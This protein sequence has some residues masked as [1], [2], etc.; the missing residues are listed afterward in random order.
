MSEAAPQNPLFPVPAQPGER[1]PRMSTAGSMRV[2]LRMAE[3]AMVRSSDSVQVRGNTAH[4]LVD[5]SEAFPAWLDAIQS[6]RHYVH[7]ENYIIRDDRIGRRFREALCDRS[8]DGIRVRV[9]YDWIGCWATPRKFWRPFRDAGV[10]LRAFAPPSASDP[11]NFLRR[12]HRKVVAVDGV[13]ASTSGM[14]IGDEWA[15]DPEAGIPAW[16]DTGVE[17]RGPVAAA[18]DRAFARSWTAA[19]GRLPR[20]EIADPADVR[21]VGH[22]AVRVVEGEPGRSRIYRL[23]QFV[24][25]GVE[26]RLWITDPYFVLPPAMA[27]ALASAARDGVDVRVLVP[28]YNNWPIVGGMSRAGYRP[29]LDA[30]VR[31]FE[32]E[33]PMIHAKTAVADG[34][35]SRVGSTNL[36]LAS[37]L[38]NW[39]LDVAVTDLDFATE[40]EALFERDLAS[41]VEITM[42]RSSRVSGL[43]IRERRKVERAPLEDPEDLSTPTVAEAREARRRSFRGSQLGRFM[44]RL[45]RAA[46]VLMRALV[47]HRTIGREDTGWVT[48]WAAILVAVSL[49]GF[50]VPR[51]LAWPIAFLVFWLAVAALIRIGGSEDPPNPPLHR[52]DPVD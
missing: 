48:L 10:D 21:P 24:A 50:L 20:E 5:G 29:L 9:L 44:G 3:R 35:W 6:A 46:T 16:R 49:L 45:A 39:E 34:F 37:L 31:L 2:M 52:G 36:N 22:V 26:R 19:G 41:S 13:Y 27:E 33:G 25:V 17:F 23:S 51:V 11:L 12:D 18:I 40:M 1:P 7:L 15:G 42:L 30:G 14:C 43:G 8:R 32:W 28:A 38:G 47:G 4:L